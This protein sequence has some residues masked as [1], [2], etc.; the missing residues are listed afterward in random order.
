MPDELDLEILRELSKDARLS[1]REIARRLDK[2]TPT[3]SRRVKRMEEA[4]L[5]QGYSVVTAGLEVL[6]E[7]RREPWRCSHCT[8]RIRGVAIVRSVG[9][10][11]R[12]FCCPVCAE[13]FKDRYVRLHEGIE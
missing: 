6:P 7:A 3:V 9:D 1:M 10:V 8:G 4:G 2:S 13:L 12:P 11:E 5:I